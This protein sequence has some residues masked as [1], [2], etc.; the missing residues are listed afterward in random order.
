MRAFHKAFGDPIDEGLWKKNDP[1]T[2]AKALEPYPGHVTGTETALYMDC[3]A[4]D[5]YGLAEGHRALG[6]ILDERNIPH[7][8]W[9]PPGDHGYDFV[10]RR[11]PESLHFIRLVFHGQNPI[12]PTRQPGIHGGVRS[13]NVNGGPKMSSTED[14]IQHS[15]PDPFV[16]F[17]E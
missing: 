10:R 4:E 3:G 9:L 8:L 12:E 6:R 13:E 1:L 14:A 16:A 11:L 5:R 7:V 2:L 15:R 17:V